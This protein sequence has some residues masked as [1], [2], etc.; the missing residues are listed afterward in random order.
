MP[1]SWVT[2][3]STRTNQPTCQAPR[4][5]ATGLRDSCLHGTSAT[6]SHDH[7]KQHNVCHLKFRPFSEPTL[8]TLWLAHTWL[9]LLSFGVLEIVVWPFYLV[10]ID[11]HPYLLFPPTWF[12]MFILGQPLIPVCLGLRDFLRAETGTVL[13]KPRSW[14]P[15]SV[16]STSGN[17]IG[18]Y[19]RHLFPAP[20]SATSHWYLEVSHGGSIYTKEVHRC[21]IVNRSK[22]EEM[23]S[24]IWELLPNSAESFTYLTDEGHSEICL[25]CHLNLSP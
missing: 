3:V 13:N 9:T 8:V 6:C 20:C 2:S 1:S 15:W 25:L 17:T 5:L 23:F 24:S 19:C 22:A 14:S 10:A 21:Y 7:L 4:S 11:S 18:W 16:T 12:L